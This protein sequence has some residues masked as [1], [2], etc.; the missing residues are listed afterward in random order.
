MGVTTTVWG[1]TMGFYGGVLL[2]LHSGMSCK[3]LEKAD[4][5][6]YGC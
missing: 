2:E 3:P 4:K 5:C 6:V 1:L